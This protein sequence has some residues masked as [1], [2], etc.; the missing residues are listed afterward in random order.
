MASGAPRPT[1][2]ARGI[3]AV[4]ARVAP[5]PARFRSAARLSAIPVPIQSSAESPE[6]LMKDRT[7]AVPSAASACRGGCPSAREPLDI[8]GSTATRARVGSA[9]VSVAR[10]RAA[11]IGCYLTG[12]HLTSRPRSGSSRPLRRRCRRPYRLHRYRWRLGRTTPARFWRIARPSRCYRTGTC[13]SGIGAAENRRLSGMASH[14]AQAAERETRA[15]S[16]AM[17]VLP[18]IWRYSFDTSM[19]ARR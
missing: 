12:R 19:N 5:R 13:N 18:Y 11:V 2:V 6:M 1:S 14:R 15:L 7:A 8:A 10:C 16:V 9:T 17:P 4:S 3:K